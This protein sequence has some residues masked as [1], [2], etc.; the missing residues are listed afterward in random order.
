MK[1]ESNSWTRTPPL[2]CLLAAFSQADAVVGCFDDGRASRDG[3]DAPAESDYPVLS[4]PNPSV[5]GK[6]FANLGVACGNA[7]RR[8]PAEDHL[9][10]QNDDG[11]IARKE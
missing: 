1:W 9:M 7:C 10:P 5:F 2:P 8:K 3:G 4:S 6:A 11:V